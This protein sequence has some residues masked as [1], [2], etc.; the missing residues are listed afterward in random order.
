MVV[1]FIIDFTVNLVASFKGQYCVYHLYVGDV[2]LWEV[3]PALSS[4]S[5]LCD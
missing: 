5:E 2:H 1:Y 4:V 3:H